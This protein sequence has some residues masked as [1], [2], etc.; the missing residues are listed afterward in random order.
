MAEHGPM[1]H[2]RRSVEMVENRTIDDTGSQVS[3][4]FD[5]DPPPKPGLSFAEKKNLLL[6]FAL[7]FIHAI[8]LQF[9]WITMPIILRQQLGYSDVGTFLVSQYPYS[10]KAIWCPLV[11]AFYMPR[12]GRRKT[13]IV[14]SFV[15]V[16]G[17]LLWLAFD[18]DS[19]VANIAQGNSLSMLWLVLAWFL[20]MVLCANIRIALDSWALTL[21][22]PPNVHWASF[23][24]TVGELAA[25]LVSFNIFLG[26]TS[27]YS[28][29]NEAGREEPARTQLFY[30]ASAI[31]CVVTGILLMIG[32]RE[33]DKG[34]AKQS[35]R[36]A[37]AI[38]WKIVSLRQVW[39]LMLVHMSSMIG[40]MTND[41]ITVLQFVKNGLSDLDI[42]G[43]ATASLPFATVGG[44][45]VA[46][47]FKTKHPLHV[48][49][50]MFPWRLALAFVSQI[51]V[52]FISKYPNSPY[53][54]FVVFLPYCFSRLLENAM[55]VAFVAFH[56]QVSDPQYGGIYM[57]LLSTTLNIRY[58]TLQFFFTKTIGFIDGTEDV[59]QP[60]ELIDG[61]Q[62]VNAAS[63]LLAIP[64]YWFFLRPTT[65]YLQ[66]VDV[67]AWRVNA[68]ESDI[69]VAY[70]LVETRDEHGHEA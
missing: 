66:N 50:N 68:T 38:M 67:S 46:R 22:S 49:R 59:T 51:T 3:V 33:Y 19:L 43:L 63:V 30:K 52:F 48:W 36:G 16:G 20:V 40:F 44:L 47:A 27:L 17:V 24:V 21:L 54:W 58:D 69:P 12:V 32:K 65:L 57:S 11:D 45:L 8:P 41:T 35:I 62:I 37:Y 5:D 15:M 14:P 7:Y 25:A 53:R 4:S 31:A 26:V 10:W 61:Y 56:A 60:S 70:E 1:L 6:L 64:I 18:Q 28:H 13:W 39:L 9:S 2:L 29:K 23:I 55:W 42:A 34:E